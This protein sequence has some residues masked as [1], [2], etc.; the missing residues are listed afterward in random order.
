MVSE[1]L[2]VKGAE[3][4]IEEIRTQLSEAA[5]RKSRT[6]LRARDAFQGVI[7]LEELHRLRADA[8]AADRDYR[9]AFDALVKAVQDS[10]TS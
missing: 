5:E 10:Q 7:A 1:V 6:A 3:M 8:D 2:I 4:T 9:I